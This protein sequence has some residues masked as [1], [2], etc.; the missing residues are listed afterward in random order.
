MGEPRVRAF[1]LAFVLAWVAVPALAETKD[2]VTAGQAEYRRSCAVCHG[3][4][5]YGDGLLASGLKKSPDNLTL[6]AKQNGG[7]FP[8]LKVIAV[9]DGRIEVLYHGRREMPLWGDRFSRRDNPTVAKARILD[10][11]LYLESIQTK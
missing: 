3:E 4:D 1:L 6:L 5:G 11:T 8:F 2:P 10:L 9:I 7:V